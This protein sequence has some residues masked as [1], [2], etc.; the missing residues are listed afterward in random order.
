[1]NSLSLLKIKR[2]QISAGSVVL[3]VSLGL[4]LT[5]MGSSAVFGQETV[6]TDARGIRWIFGGSMPRCTGSFAETHSISLADVI[7]EDAAQGEGPIQPVAAPLLV[8]D[9]LVPDDFALN[10]SCDHLSQR[11]SRQLRDGGFVRTDFRESAGRCRQ[12]DRIEA[13]GRLNALFKT[14]GNSEYAHQLREY[15][16]YRVVY[17][18]LLKVVGDQFW[19]SEREYDVP[20]EIYSDRQSRALS[21]RVCVSDIRGKPISA[22]MKID[23]AIYQSAEVA[24]CDSNGDEG[25]SLSDL[26][27]QNPTRLC[28]LKSNRSYAFTIEI[29]KVHSHQIVYRD[30]SPICDGMQDLGFSQGESYIYELPLRERCR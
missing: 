6:M 8:D 11:Q 25:K 2:N 29:Q 23:K 10:G 21:E 14:T 12:H 19:I 9:F 3:I 15:S 13:R 27:A 17:S 4:S 7:D 20:F 28:E 24:I 5:V 30:R 1:M 26:V 16:D 22:E 18:H